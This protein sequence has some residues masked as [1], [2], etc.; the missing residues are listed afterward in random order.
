VPVSGLLNVRHAL[1]NRGPFDRN[2]YGSNP[3]NKD[4]G[5]AGNL[6]P[7]QTG[8][9]NRRGEDST[10]LPPDFKNRTPPSPVLENSPYHSDAVRDRIKPSYQKNDAHD[11]RHPNFNPKKDPEPSDAAD[12]YKDAVR[13]NMKTWFGIGEGGKIYRFFHDNVSTVHFSGFAR[14]VDVPGTV[15]RLL[16][17]KK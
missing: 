10:S 3:G 4:K 9:G 1:R 8:N 13:A 5:V 7:G 14:E 17:L 16:G 11:K 15:L 2:L 6:K 12:V